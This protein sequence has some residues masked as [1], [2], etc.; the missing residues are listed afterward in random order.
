MIP[1]KQ[2]DI[3]GLIVSTPGFGNAPC[4]GRCGVGLPGYRPVPGLPL[5]A[6]APVPNVVIPVPDQPYRPS[7]SPSPAPKSHSGQVLLLATGAKW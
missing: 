7:P 5:L 2:N 6:R 4:R 1:M 3:P